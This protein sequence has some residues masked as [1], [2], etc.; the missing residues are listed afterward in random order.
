MKTYTF[1]EIREWVERDNDVRSFYYL[2]PESEVT[3][4]ELDLFR[5]I[6][7][8]IKLTDEESELREEI[9]DNLYYEFR[10]YP[11]KKIEGGILGDFFLL[12]RPVSE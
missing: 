8:C 4:D 11:G 6:S 12:E 7:K 10:I 9:F 5:K 1:L 2:I 3:K